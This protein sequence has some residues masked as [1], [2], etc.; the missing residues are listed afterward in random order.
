MEGRHQTEASR[1][2]WDGMMMIYLF[3]DFSSFVHLSST[4]VNSSSRGGYYFSR[5]SSAY[6]IDYTKFL[7][8]SRRVHDLVAGIGCSL[9]TNDAYTCDASSVLLIRQ[10][11][12]RC[13]RS[14]SLVDRSPT[15][16]CWS[17]WLLLSSVPLLL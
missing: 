2:E 13:G 8:P 7:P 12:D 6:D 15:P 16:L 5:I 1:H 11:L 10:T 4:F 3:T 9:S 14:L 17:T